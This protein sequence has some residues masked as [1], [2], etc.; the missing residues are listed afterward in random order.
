MRSLQQLGLDCKGWDPVYR[1]NVPK[2]SADAINLGYVLNVIEDVRERSE[3][4]DWSYL[5][6]SKA[7]R[8]SFGVRIS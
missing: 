7:L 4:L 5:S 3:T 8:K 6:S 2:C 1:A